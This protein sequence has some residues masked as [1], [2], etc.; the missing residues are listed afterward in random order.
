[1][2]MMM[3]TT[4]MRLVV[5]GGWMCNVTRQFASKSGSSKTWLQRQ[6]NDVYT[7]KAAAE[8]L[9][10]RSAYKLM[11]IQNSYHF[12]KPTDFVVDLGAAP[13]GWSVYVANEILNLWDD[14]A[15]GINGDNAPKVHHA[16][17]CDDAM[18][19]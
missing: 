9:R 18:M 17:W 2:P 4:M 15:T 6:R 19:L 16:K 5:S 13:G 1:M 12:I 10:A 14:S 8:G 3:K 7:K 11:E